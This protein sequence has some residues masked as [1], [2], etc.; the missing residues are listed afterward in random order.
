MTGTEWSAMDIAK[1]TYFDETPSEC[2][3]PMLIEFPLFLQM[4]QSGLAP[5]PVAGVSVISAQEKITAESLAEP[6]DVNSLL[7][8]LDD[9]WENDAAIRDSMTESEYLEFRN[10]IE[11]SNE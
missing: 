3:Y 8:W 7:N 4:T 1:G 2:G 6:V 10:S 11:S 5:A 9:L